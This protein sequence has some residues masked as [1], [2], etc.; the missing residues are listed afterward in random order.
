M[1]PSDRIVQPPTLASGI[2]SETFKGGGWSIDSKASCDRMLVA[3]P[4]S[5]RILEKMVPPKLRLMTSA[6]SWGM[7]ILAISLSFK[8]ILSRTR[9]SCF[10][11][12]IWHTG[13]FAF[14]VKACSRFLEEAASS[15]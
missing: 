14:S 13:R 12:S 5:T 11:S 4:V 2:F 8:I 6:S 3:P 9:A 10:R 1:V 15:I 7:S